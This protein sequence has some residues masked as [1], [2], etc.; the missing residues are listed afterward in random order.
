MLAMVS[1]GTQVA[2]F[3]TVFG[4]VLGA[5]L[6]GV[7]CADTDP[8]YGPPEAIKG[9]EIEFGNTS[10]GMMTTTDSGGTTGKSA[11]E[12]FTPLRASAKNSCSPCHDPNGTKTGITF[13]VG[14]DENDAYMIWKAKNYQDITA[15]RTF[16]TRGAHTGPAL[17]ADQKT[18][19][20]QWAAAEKAGGGG[21]PVT[22]AGGGGG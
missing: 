12:L 5:A 20:E 6:F 18:L 8:N 4:S 17:T 13:F 11:R 14:N 10:G 21:T 15:P 7:G 1:R 9:R 22:D 19:C 16:Y 2:L 3:L